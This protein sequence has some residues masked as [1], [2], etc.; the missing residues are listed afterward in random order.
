MPVHNPTAYF[1]EAVK[2]TLSALPTDGELVIIDDASFVGYELFRQIRDPRVSIHRVDS[3]VGVARALNV[4]FA[5]AR[6]EYIARMDAD[7]ICLEHRFRHQSQVLEESKA[8]LLFGGIQLID[9]TGSIIQRRIRLPDDNIPWKKAGM[10]LS[11]SNP[12]AHP[13]L[14]A[15]RVAFQQL[16]PYRDTPAEDYEM[17]MRGYQAGLRLHKDSV[18]VLQYRVHPDQVS[19][20]E[21]FEYFRL[22]TV[23]KDTHDS[24]LEKLKYD[25][26]NWGWGQKIEFIALS[27]AFAL[28]RFWSKLMHWRTA[29]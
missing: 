7:D 13:T 26:R 24:L 22:D 28:L 9:H 16:L 21:N 4:G 23:F 11:V 8:D 6:G 19:R 14:F 5:E 18:R 12:F 20:S 25:S 17:W 15:K 10:R 2:S 27:S 1:L 3:N 29:W